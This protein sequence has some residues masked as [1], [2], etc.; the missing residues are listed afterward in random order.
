MTPEGA[1]T[2]ASPHVTD[3]S[4]HSLVNGSSQEEHRSDRLEF[5]SE[6]THFPRRGGDM[7][8]STSSVIGER[9]EGEGQEEADKRQVAARLVEPVTN[10]G[11][12]A[13]TDDHTS[14]LGNR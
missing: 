9:E 12:S 11:Q 5:S 10:Q 6:E 3:K 1:D 13:R 14:Q 7:V 8:D 4:N 2:Q